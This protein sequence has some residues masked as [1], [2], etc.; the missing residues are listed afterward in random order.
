MKTLEDYIYEVQFTIKYHFGNIGLLY[1]AFKRRSY[2]MENGGVHNETLEF[3]G[4]RVLDYF[5]TKIIINRYGYLNN[6]GYFLTKNYINE[7]MLTELKKKFV[8][9]RMLAHQIDEMGLMNYLYMGRGDINLNQQNEDSVKEDLFEAILGA[10]AIDSNW[11]PTILENAVKLMLNIEYYLNKGF[12]NEKDYVS[13][14]Q[15][16]NQKVNG[17]VPVYQFDELQYGI[18]RANLYL[19]TIRG[20]IHYHAIGHSKSQARL[21]VAEIAYKDLKSNNELLTIMDELPSTLTLDN[22]IN[23]LQE[24]FQK[25][26]ISMPE[27]DIPDI[28]VY[29]N[30]GNRRWM[31]TCY[32]RSED[33]KRT[34]YASSKS[35]AKK[36]SAY[37]CICQICGLK[38]QYE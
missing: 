15:Q 24:L 36:Y 4:D 17:I 1:Q 3:V 20:L 14:I 35:I 28:Q 31:C 34:A 11:N 19:H 23:T 32:I 2:S 5:V 12:S 18:F 10:I 13:L 9:K 7:G 26:Y 16:W 25:G 33:I 21:L 27:Y 6:E 38:N 29:D 37:L 30:N 22:A 8:N